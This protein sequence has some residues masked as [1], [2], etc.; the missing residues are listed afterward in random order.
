[1]DVL[2]QV[3]SVLL[4]FSLLGA[5]LWALRR[6]GRISFQGLARKRIPGQTKS[7]VAVER[8]ALTP[9]HTLHLVCINGREV[10]VATHPQGC[11]VVSDAVESALGAKA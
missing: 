4:V 1:M 9:Q 7:M 11:S 6:G 2:R 8:L 10:L 5:V 3:F